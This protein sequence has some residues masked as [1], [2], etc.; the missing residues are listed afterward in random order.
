M[1]INGRPYEFLVIGTNGERPETTDGHVPLAH[2][3]TYSI[4][5]ASSVRCAANI[6]IDGV[7]VG[8]F[9]VPAWQPITIERPADVSRLFTFFAVDTA[10]A[11]ASRQDSIAN[12]NRGL[13]EVVFTPEKERPMT[14]VLRS[15]MQT[16]GLD[17]SCST[18]GGCETFG[19]GVTGLT[20]Q[21]DQRFTSVHMDLDHSQAV[22]LRVRLVIDAGRKVASAVQPLSGHIPTETPIPRMAG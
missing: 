6:K 5:L 11:A 4:K 17:L 7:S 15:G 9:V 2:G 13:V 16:R 19:A 20:G 21:S 12:V 22:T 18:K 10:E 3:E 1:K 14:G 8:E